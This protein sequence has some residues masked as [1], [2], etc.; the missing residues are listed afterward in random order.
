MF[1]ASE[2][3]QSENSKKWYFSSF[4]SIFKFV[5]L[6]H[7]KFQFHH[8]KRNLKHKT[9]KGILRWKTI[10]FVCCIGILIVG[11]FQIDLWITN[12]RDIKTHPHLSPII[13]GFISSIKV[14]IENF[15]VV[16]TFSMEIICSCNEKTDL[17]IFQILLFIM[18]HLDI[19]TS[20]S[21]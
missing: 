3:Y 2:F 7:Y 8:Q 9:Y 12:F 6:S 15:W 10:D 16:E 21:P 5:F 20:R 14:P 19:E 17:P 4:S 18:F 1:L 13:T 11:N